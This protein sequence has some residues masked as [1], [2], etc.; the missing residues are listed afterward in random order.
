MAKRFSARSVLGGLILL[1]ALLLAVYTAGRLLDGPVEQVVDLARPEADLAMQTIHYTETRNGERVWSLQADS[2]AHDLESGQARVEAIHMTVYDRRN[3]DIRI[4]AQRG[5]L[6]LQQRR[7]RLRGEVVVTTASG[8]VLHA[9]DLLFSDLKRTVTTD[10]PVTVDGPGY[11][12]SGVG[13]VYEIDTRRLQL[14]S[15]VD[16]QFSG[17]ITVP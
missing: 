5:E 13:L 14:R 11:S 6:D 7:V 16:A 15:Q 17:R 3:G 8:Q 2:A 9:D 4:D 1:L 12:V 10:G